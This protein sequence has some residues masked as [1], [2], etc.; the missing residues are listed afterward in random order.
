MNSV[1]RPSSPAAMEQSEI[2]IWR[3]AFSPCHLCLRQEA[4]MEI[5]HAGIYGRDAGQS[6]SLPQPIFPNSPEYSS[7][8]LCTDVQFDNG[9]SF[10]PSAWNTGRFSRRSWVSLK[11]RKYKESPCSSHGCGVGW[12]I[13]R[14]IHC[15]G[16]S[17]LP[18][19]PQKTSASGPG[20]QCN[21]AR[22]DNHIKGTS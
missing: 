10:Y 4:A 11:R 15:S 9:N 6:S 8:T 7:S 19:P 1:L 14:E 12:K 21:I 22:P 20:Q 5:P 2:P 13:P 16:R 17:D 3:S 18:L